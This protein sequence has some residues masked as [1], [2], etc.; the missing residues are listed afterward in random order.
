MKVTLAALALVFGAGT[1]SAQ[2]YAAANGYRTCPADQTTQGIEIVRDVCGA[3]KPPSLTS[4]NFSSL[5]ELRAAEAQRVAFEQDVAAFGQCVTGFI[6]SYRRPG[7]DASSAAPDQAA[8]A[9]AWAE[10][11]ATQLVR[12]FGRACV[13]FSNRS[14]VDGTIEPWSGACYPSAG[15]G[16]G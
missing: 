8:C 6:Q 4:A 9:H 1:A 10:D 15:S 7:A 13:D 14:M 12:D 11:Q 2:Q 5:D 16:Q 3:L